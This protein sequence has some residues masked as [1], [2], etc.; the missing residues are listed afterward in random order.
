MCVYVKICVFMLEGVLRV[1]AQPM[2]GLINTMVSFECFLFPSL[3]FSSECLTYIRDFR[4]NR[5]N[6]QNLSCLNVFQ[7]LR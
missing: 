7:A 1:C 4:R 2:S 3:Y 6:R 5:N